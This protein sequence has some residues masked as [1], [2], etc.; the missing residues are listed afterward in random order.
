MVSVHDGDAILMAQKLAASL[1]LA[2]GISSGANF[3]GALMVQKQMGADAVV[4]TVFPDDNKKYLSTDLLR[5]ERVNDDYL[6]PEVE[7][8]STKPSSE[9][10]THVLMAK[11]EWALVSQARPSAIARYHHKP[12]N[13]HHTTACSLALRPTVRICATSRAGQHRCRRGA[14]HSRR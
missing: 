3:I 1:G 8:L 7:L 4:A 12:H 14:A 2:V 6:A 10:V 5:E 13:H 9:F 11:G